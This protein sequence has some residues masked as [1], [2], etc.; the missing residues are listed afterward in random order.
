MRRFVFLGVVL[1]GS[2]LPAAAQVSTETDEPPHIGPSETENVVGKMTGKLARGFVN[3]VTCSAEV[4]NQSGKTGHSDGF[5]AAI[6]LGLLKGIGMSI[7]RFAAGS[8]D[9]VFFLSPWP[10]DWKPILEPEYVWE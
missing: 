6:T 9:L 5:W 8:F 7:V 2:A 3:M 1:L 4:P 10:D